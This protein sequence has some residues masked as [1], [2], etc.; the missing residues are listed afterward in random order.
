MKQSPEALAE[1]L[2]ILREERN[3]SLQSL[4]ELT[5]VSK[6]MLRQIETGKSN[7][8][9]ETLWKIANGLRI[10]FTSLLRNRVPRALLRN[11]R[12]EEPLMDGARGYR[13]YPVVPFD[14]ER[15]FELYYVEMDPGCLMKSEPHNGVV[16]EHVLVLRGN[17]SIRVEDREYRVCREQCLSFVA[18]VPHSYENTGETLAFAAM[19][20]SYLS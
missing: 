11:F 4:A 1:N 6:S 10:S 8:T 3:L 9:I 16:E 15:G 19:V 2:R 13:A 12:D 18:N 20:L 17:F 5:G 14:P 7:P